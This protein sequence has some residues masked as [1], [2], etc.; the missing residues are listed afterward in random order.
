MEANPNALDRL[1]L[2]FRWGHYG[3]HVLRCHLTSFAPGRSV[4]FHK[5]SEFE[6]HFIPRGKGKVIMHNKEFSLG[7]G[8][9]YLTGP[10]LLHYQE[11][12]AIES[13]DELCLHIDIVSLENSSGGDQ[14][15]SE[16][17]SEEAEECIRRLRELPEFPVVDQYNAMQWFLAAYRAWS[18]NQHGAYTTI[19]QSIIQILL[20]SVRNYGGPKGPFELP[21]RDMNYYRYQLASQFMLDNYTNPITLKDV[22]EK[23]HIS[24]RQLQRI[25][26]E[27]EAG[28]FSEH[29]ENIRLSRVCKELLEGENSFELISETHG[30]SSSNYLYSVFKKR[31]GLT[32]KQYRKVQLQ[33]NEK[34][35]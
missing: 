27:N 16:L 15:G 13:M 18:E 21:V 11:A 5:H 3:I 32:P 1:D 29:L 20:R 24:S 28:S 22:A 10:E 8:S 12:D 26:Q 25:F 19:K 9:F 30:F 31:F 33:L 34:G 17:E 23:I 6:F 14:W 35:R 7:E 4:A 2:K